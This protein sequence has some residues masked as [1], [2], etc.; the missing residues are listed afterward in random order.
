MLQAWGKRIDETKEFCSF[1]GCLNQARGPSLLQTRGE[2]IDWA[3]AIVLE[4]FIMRG[5]SD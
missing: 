5:Y 3:Q 2:I 4:H 1:E